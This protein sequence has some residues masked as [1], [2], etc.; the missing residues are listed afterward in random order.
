MG[1]VVTLSKSN[2]AK[3]ATIKT[4]NNG[5]IYIGENCSVNA[6]TFV[7]ADNGEIILEKKVSVNRNSLIVCRKKISIG[8]GTS[9]GP[10]VL[11]YDHDHLIDESGFYKD[12]FT[13]D[14]IIIGKNVWIAGNCCILKGTIIGDNCVIGAGT[15]VKENV[16]PDT[17][18]MNKCEHKYI[19]I[20][21]RYKNA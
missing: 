10:N 21:E 14:E 20:K 9:I 7:C 18:L 1:G 8:E 11:I 15:V 2:I 19:D 13:C 3:T 6:N 17:I 4:V 5:K 12:K 16:A